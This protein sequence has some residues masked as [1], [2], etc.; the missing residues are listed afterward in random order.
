MYLSFLEQISLEMPNNLNK[1][2]TTKPPAWLV[3]FFLIFQ[4]FGN[5]HP[6]YK[7]IFFVTETLVY[8]YS[9]GSGIWN[10]NFGHPESVKDGFQA[11]WTT[12]F[13]IAKIGQKWKI[14]S[15]VQ[16][17]SSRFSMTNFQPKITQGFEYPIC[18]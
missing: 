4:N 18:Q 14:C 12:G 11:S 6:A 1:F 9:D 16:H 10:Q 15:F 13:D 7:K 3:S 5:Y 17:A 2:S 8:Y